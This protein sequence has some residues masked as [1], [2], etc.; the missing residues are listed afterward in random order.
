MEAQQR[1]LFSFTTGIEDLLRNDRRVV[2]AVLVLIILCSWFFVL[3][4]AG[5]GMSTLAMT[6]WEMAIGAP[7]ALGHALAS[8]VRW[9]AQY[10]LAMVLMWWGMMIAMMLPSAAPIIL[11]YARIV[12]GRDTR[13]IVFPATG[14]FLAGYTIVWGAFSILAVTLQWLFEMSGLLSPFMMNGTSNLFAAAI[15]LY[16]GLYQLSPL[17][18]TCLKSCQGPLQFLRRHWRPGTSG[19]LLMGL[20][21]GAFCLGCCLGLMTILFFGGVMN[22][23]WIVGLAM[24]VFIEK[25]VI[26][27]YWFST[28]T[29]L[30]LL[31]A[32]VAFISRHLA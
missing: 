29:G 26:T 1:D 23:Y 2:A 22:L 10:A 13:K 18:R 15:L 31:A 20:L 3:A 28:V 9:D 8:P 7:S 25:V 11:L 4:G 32:S 27:G 14:V 24:L 17:K 16:A 5:T 30:V 19:A 12:R 6:S 21:H